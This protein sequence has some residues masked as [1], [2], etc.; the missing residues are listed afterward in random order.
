[1]KFWLMYVGVA[2]RID[3]TDVYHCP[4]L[5]VTSDK[6]IT[7]VQR[8]DTELRGLYGSLKMIGITTAVNSEEREI[9]EE[10][11]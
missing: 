6:M 2:V 11:I 5:G 3:Q 1:M 10:P 7:A 4:A 9:T 8:I